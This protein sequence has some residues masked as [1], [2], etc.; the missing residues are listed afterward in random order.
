MSQERLDRAE[1]ERMVRLLHEHRRGGGGS[2]LV[3]VIHPEA[4]MRLLIIYGTVLRGGATIIRA[5]ESARR[6][7]ELYDA[8]VR[9]FEWLDQRTLLVFGHARYALPGGGHAEG[10][11]YWLDE[12]RDGRIWRAHVFMREAGARRAYEER[13]EERASENR[14]LRER[15]DNESP[16]G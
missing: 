13:F 4:E 16:T 15:T 9:R 2:D 7:A 12:F 14:N 3:A 11:V 5:L 10:R 6:N 1:A 8:S